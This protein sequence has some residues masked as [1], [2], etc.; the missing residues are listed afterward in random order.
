VRPETIASGITSER[1]AR[2]LAREAK[3]AAIEGAAGVFEARATVLEAVD[4]YVETLKGRSSHGTMERYARLHL[5]DALA[6]IDLLDLTRGQVQGL[7]DAKVA[8]GFSPQTV[9][10]IV[11]LLRSAWELA[12]RRNLVGERANPA[13]DLKLPRMK[14]RVKERLSGAEVDAVVAELEEPWDDHLVCAVELMLRPGELYALTRAD[15]DLEKRIVI[16]RRS[17]ERAE[18]KTGNERIVAVSE[19]AAAALKRALQRSKS[20]LVFPAPDG[21]MM[22]STTDANLTRKLRGAMVR[23]AEKG[24]QTLVTHWTLKCRRKLSDRSMCGYRRDVDEYTREERC[25]KCNMRLWPSGHARNVRW[26]DL[27]HTGASLWIERGV[28]AAA[29]SAMLGHHD[30]AFTFKTYV[31][32]SASGL[33]NEI[34]RASSTRAAPVLPRAKKRAT[35]P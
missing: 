16:V 25:P 27:R 18:T 35:K 24:C 12:R 32:L 30:V 4:A 17:W 19:R 11:G 22:P 34:D 15:V 5:K 33:R 26:Y 21:S 31:S 13:T 3:R 23:A 2:R 8:G 28:S 7:V 14:A 10:H 20:E 1:E 29:V 6:G 9:R